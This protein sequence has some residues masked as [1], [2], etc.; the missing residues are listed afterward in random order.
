MSNK[1]NRSL[2]SHYN[3]GTYSTDGAAIVSVMG[4]QF[5]VYKAIIIAKEQPLVG[6]L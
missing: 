2:G 6:T 3:S 4:N 5:F 1:I